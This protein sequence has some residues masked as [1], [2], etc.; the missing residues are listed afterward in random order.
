MTVTKVLS[1]HYSEET[2]YMVNDYPYGFKL[3]CKI[4]YW[5][6]VNKNGT[7]LVT[8]T[9][10]PKKSYE[11]WNAPKMSTY[12]LVGAMFL[13]E[14]NHVQ[15]SGLSPYDVSKIREYLGTYRE[16]LQEKQI[17]MLER[18]IAAYEKREAA[19]QSL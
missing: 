10:N 12:S 17:E 1:G 11:H 3:R 13:N 14:E 15:W 6:E 7:R 18:L 9:T 4:K 5:L 19:K 16:G 2:A 8:R